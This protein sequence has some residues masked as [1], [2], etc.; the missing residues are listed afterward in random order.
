MTV[1]AP[2]QGSLRAQL[3]TFFSD[4]PNQLLAR[5]E[6]GE[7]FFVSEKTIQAVITR[8]NRDGQIRTLFGPNRTAFYVLA[9]NAIVK[10]PRPIKEPKPTRRWPGASSYVPPRPIPISIF[11]W[12]P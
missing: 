8:L 1:R 3:L 2:N 9:S 11:E 5:S 7:R 10:L 6:I 12:R 4:N